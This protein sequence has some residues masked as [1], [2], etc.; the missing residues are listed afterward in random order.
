M[1]EVNQKTIVGRECKFVVHIPSKHP[2]DDDLH[3]IKEKIYYS[4][5]TTIRETRLIRNYKRSIWVTRPDKRN[6]KQK[7]E[8]EHIDNLLEKQLAEFIRKWKFE[9]IEKPGD[10]TEVI[11]PFVFKQENINAAVVL[12][13]ILLSFAIFIPISLL[14]G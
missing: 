11:Y 3:Y 13:T 6:H 14:S 12:G 2:D 1:S 10:V 5:D 7:K 8:W 9:K 4:D